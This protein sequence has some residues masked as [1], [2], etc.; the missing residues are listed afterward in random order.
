MKPNV[1]AFMIKCLN[2]LEWMKQEKKELWTKWMIAKHWVSDAIIYKF[3]GREPQKEFPPIEEVQKMRETLSDWKIA[4]EL[5]VSEV[6]IRNHCGVK[7]IVPRSQLVKDLFEKWLD[8]DQIA[9]ELWISKQSAY[10][11]IR[12]IISPNKV[13]NPATRAKDDLKERV[14]NTGKWEIK[15][16]TYE[17]YG[18]LVHVGSWPIPWVNLKPYSGVPYML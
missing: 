6:W 10:Y 9:E 17:V 5:W 7:D 13:K 14:L 15:E 8:I 1:K 3:L 12:K 16:H 18:E 4:T 2:D 11:H